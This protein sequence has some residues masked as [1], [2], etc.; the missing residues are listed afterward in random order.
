MS[1]S[2]LNFGNKSTSNLVLEGAA[3]MHS[4][5]KDAVQALANKAET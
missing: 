2:L 3:L 5:A 1:I 4:G